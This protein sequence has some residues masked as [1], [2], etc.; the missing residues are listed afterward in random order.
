MLNE[1]FIR[2]YEKDTITNKK[3]P[4]KV[5]LK[6]TPITYYCLL[7]YSKQAALIKKF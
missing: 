6:Y 3:C 4:I 2:S 5:L 7:D 1:N